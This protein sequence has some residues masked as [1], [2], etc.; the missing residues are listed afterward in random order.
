MQQGRR[1][2]RVGAG[3]GR[4]QRHGEY[5]TSSPVSAVIAAGKG[6]MNA[7]LSNCLPAA[8]TRGSPGP[9]LTK[10]A[11]ASRTHF[12]HEQGAMSAYRELTLVSTE[13]VEGRLPLKRLKPRRLCHSNVAR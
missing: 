8:E 2:I 1:K 5:S 13:T 11:I 12:G 3:A 9:T 10:H 6:P 4:G 7:F